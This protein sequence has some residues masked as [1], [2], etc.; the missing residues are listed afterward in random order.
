MHR[1]EA[2][3]WA[4]AWIAFAVPAQAQFAQQD[5]LMAT[6]AVGTS[7]Q[8]KSVAVSADGSTAAV[9]APLDNNGAGAVWVYARING[10]WTQQARLLGSDVSKEVA[11]QGSS[12]AL[13]ADGNTLIIGGMDDNKGTGAMWIFVRANGV[14]TQQGPK[15]WGTVLLGI[16]HQGVSVALSADGNTALVGG[17][18]D[19]N[20]TGAAWV[21]TRTDGKWGLIPD[22]LI[23]VGA[24]GESHQGAAVAL[25]ADG[26]AALVGG[27]GDNSEIGAAWVFTRGNG[28]WTQQ[29]LKL[30]GSGASAKAAV[31]SA[32]AL[33]ADGNTAVVGGSGDSG[34]AG[35]LWVFT[36]AGT[37]WSP[38]GGKLVG[39]EAA[40]SRLLG[41]SVALTAD[42]NT[43]LAG[44]PGSTFGLF[45]RSPAVGA[46]W[47]FTRANGAWSQQAKLVGGTTGND[48]LQ[49]AAVA[50]SADGGTAMIGG[51]AE[52]SGVGAA[53]VFT[54]TVVT[55]PVILL[56]P[57]GPT[58][59]SGQTAALSVSAVGAAP[60]SYQWY[61][62]P[63]GN[64]TTPLGT[65][66]ST[67][68]TPLLAVTT[69]FWVRV[70]NPFGSTDSSTATVTVPVPGPLITQVANAASNNPNI[71][72]NTWVAIQGANLAGTTRTWEAADFANDQMPKQLD[73]VSATVNGKS[74][75]IYYISP[76]Q[77]NILTPPDAIEGTVMVQA[78]NGGLAGNSFTAQAQARS[79]SFFV[80]GAGP[81][82]AATHADGSY[83]GP[84]TLYP[85]VTTPA[86][87]GETVV[88]YGNG[89]GT[90]STP[91]VPGSS[92]QSGT[93]P[94][95][96]AIQIGGITA[97]VLFAG[98]VAP[99][100]FQFN[101]VVPLNVP[102]GDN[103][104]TALYEGSVT[105]SGVVLRVER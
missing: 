70:S 68:T 97:S 9:G 101:V 53:W 81:H 20:A 73:G 57:V 17:D 82:V 56:Q 51:P 84:A 43:A 69:S 14:W 15:Q 4:A 27:P 44:G 45:G 42:G 105:Q 37:Q 25:S 65:N 104:V 52:N 30:T 31:G 88:L 60:L 62:G 96:P 46:T 6:G 3:V 5:K 83:L 12:V 47:V 85:G 19:T 2:A 49:G 76:T 18:L 28:T 48:A 86:K 7:A 41:T 71:A 64:T 29:G 21:F 38:Q 10:R 22:K 55:P 89:F 95:T 67:F 36:R 75:Y 80:F 78:T 61:Q 26:N 94:A 90:T 87:P 77:V 58:I 91:V 63:S 39:S 1:T 92:V 13:S 8:G 33:S 59:T 24:L 35:A 23:G 100:E 54:R 79:P 99:G 11:S 16:A 34:T 93:L 98:L 74:A 66:A 103:A 72:P 50:V 102:D 40:P 32:V